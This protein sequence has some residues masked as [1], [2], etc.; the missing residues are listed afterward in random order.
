MIIRLNRW[1][2]QTKQYSGFEF[3][4]RFIEREREREETWRP[5]RTAKLLFI[6]MFD[7]STNEPRPNSDIIMCVC[8]KDGSANLKMLALTAH[9]WAQHNTEEETLPIY[10][11]IFSQCT[12]YNKYLPRSM[13]EI[14]VS[15]YKLSKENCEGVKSKV[16]SGLWI[17]I[18]ENHIF[19]P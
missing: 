10:R 11:D 12:W 2:L 18:N 6:H 15:K 8:T 17:L 5:R 13:T 16:I 19:K 9:G 4:S 3:A 14:P 1:T 7:I